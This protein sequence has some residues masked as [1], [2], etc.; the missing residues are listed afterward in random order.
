MVRGLGSVSEDISKGKTEGTESIG[1]VQQSIQNV[2]KESISIL[3]KDVANMVSQNQDQITQIKNEL[4]G[5]QAQKKAIMES[6]NDFKSSYADAKQKEADE[7][8]AAVEK[9]QQEAEEAAASAAA[10][11]QAFKDQAKQDSED[12]A[13]KAADEL[14][15]ALQNAKDEAEKAATQAAE[16]LEKAV[17]A[18]KQE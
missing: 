2:L 4:S 10:S 9:A 5:H 3:T 18:A 15:E 6:L 12:A 1:G 17:E 14:A 7:Q 11:L 13:K 16:D 8:K